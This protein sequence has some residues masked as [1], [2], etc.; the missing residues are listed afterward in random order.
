M[1][2][3]A[4][5]ANFSRGILSPELYGR[6]DV[7]AYQAGARQL[8]NVIILK[9]GGVTKR[10]GTRLVAEVY[11]ASQPVR[12]VPFQFSL[13]QA[14]ALELGQGYMRPAANGGMVVEEELFITNATRSN[15]VKITAQ[16]HG[17]AAGDQVY[18]A[19]I[20]GMSELNGRILRV[21]GSI[22]DDNFTVDVD[23]VGFGEFLSASGGIV[24]AD[25]PDVI[26]P[27]VVPP[28]VP[29]PDPPVV[30]G[31]GRKGIY[32]HDTDIY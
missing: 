4:S 24:R 8:K 19:G 27:P 23:G 6:F 7:S 13:E 5:Q 16:N 1:V 21:V 28:V 2:F 26:V 31:G 11:D 17:Y 3:R 15:P 30:V 29:P 9:Y 20:V 32:D 18:F 14:Y 22:D 25:P 12:L 10:P